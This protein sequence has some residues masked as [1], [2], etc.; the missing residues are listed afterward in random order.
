M[1]TK[2]LLLVSKVMLFALRATYNTYYIHCVG[3]TLH[4]FNIKP[5][6]QHSYH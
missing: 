5:G 4:F 6:G 1:N 2:Q 3:K